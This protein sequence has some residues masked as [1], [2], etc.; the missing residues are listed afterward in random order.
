MNIRTPVIVSFCL[1]AAMLAIA[2]W[3]WQASP[4]LAR[5]PVHWGL[6]GQPNGWAPKSKALLMLP[7][8]AVGLTVLFAVLPAIEPRRRNLISSRQLYYAGWIG[9]LVVLAI[10]QYL[11]AS[12]AVGLHP[13]ISRTTLFAV[14][15][16]YLVLANFLGK[17]RST[18]FV[19][20]RLPWTLTSELAWEKSNRLMGRIFVATGFATLACLLL[21]RTIVAMAVFGIG[22]VVGIVASSIA[23]YIW[24][25]RDDNRVTGD[26]IHE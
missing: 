5:I 20:V 19:G 14:A 1:I 22:T 11:I 13:D 24:W 15:C 3:A 10:A 9:G 12:T 6:N 16:L 25:K 2:A 7:V 4:P 23:S 17:S 21:E 26:S 8:T 18:F